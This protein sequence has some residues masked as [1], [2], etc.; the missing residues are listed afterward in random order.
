MAAWTLK[1]I[2]TPRCIEMQIS[3]SSVAKRRSSKEAKVG[4]KMNE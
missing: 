2:Q 4:K 1:L 3:P